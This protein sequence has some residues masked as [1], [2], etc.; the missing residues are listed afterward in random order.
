MNEG[1]NTE[2][3]W[4]LGQLHMTLLQFLDCVQHQGLNNARVKYYGY[5]CV[6]IQCNELT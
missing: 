4:K 1:R 2:V 6:V 3:G 5:M